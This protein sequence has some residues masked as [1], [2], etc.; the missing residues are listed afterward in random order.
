MAALLSWCVYIE[1][2][3]A[4]SHAACKS[5]SNV[6]VLVRTG[7]LAPAVLERVI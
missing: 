1:V 3:Q 7:C 5:M 4:L 6:L 2:A